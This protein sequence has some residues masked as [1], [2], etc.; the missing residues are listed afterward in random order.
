MG[1]AD[2]MIS[3]DVFLSSASVVPGVPLEEMVGV[4]ALL[5]VLL[6]SSVM[7]LLPSR[8]FLPVVGD[9]VLAMLATVCSLTASVCLA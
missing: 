2:S 3:S 7:F 6:I 1:Q 4:L 9:F 5:C 8:Q